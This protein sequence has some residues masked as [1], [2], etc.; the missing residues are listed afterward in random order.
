MFDKGIAVRRGI[1]SILNKNS[2]AVP[3]KNADKT[4]KRTISIPIYPSLSDKEVAHI[5][6]AINKYEII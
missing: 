1:D 4:L 5:Y 2:N 6:K 3:F